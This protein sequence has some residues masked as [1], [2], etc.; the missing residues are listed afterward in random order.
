MTNQRPP[1][2]DSPWFWLIV[3]SCS[4]L[5]GLMAIAP[6]YSVRQ[7]GVERKSAAR[8][9]VARR[10]HAEEPFPQENAGDVVVDPTQQQDLRIPLA[11]LVA[12]MLLLVA[13]I[14]IAGW[15]LRGSMRMHHVHAAP[16]GLS[17]GHLT[18]PH[19]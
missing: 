2:T 4:A 15:K 9:E 8:E 12:T 16:E 19:S 11:T 18:E 6:K 3:F 7:A 14:A 10:R 5:A 1:I 17:A 13:I